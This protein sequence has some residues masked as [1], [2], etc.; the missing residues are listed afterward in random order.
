M[1][2]LLLICF[3]ILA[4]VGCGKKVLTPEE[5]YE[6]VARYQKLI[7]KSD[8]TED[9]KKFKEEMDEVVAGLALKSDDKDSKEW[10]AAFMKYEQ[11]ET[12][13]II[14]KVRKEKTEEKKSGKIS[15]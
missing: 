14:E 8:L 2:K 9:E 11:N 7:W 6:R 12:A 15:F 13:E 4:I 5:K 1:R 10:M 3:V